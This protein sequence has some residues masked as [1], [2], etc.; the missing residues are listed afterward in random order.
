MSNTRYS[1]QGELYLGDKYLATVSYVL[2][3]TPL[4][5]GLERAVFAS[6]SGTMKVIEGERNLM[7]L[8]ATFTLHM[9]DDQELDVLI[10]SQPA[11]PL[12]Q[13]GG[14]YRITSTGTIRPS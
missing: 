2:T 11:I 1:G 9:E 13:Y 5:M 7:P 3:H 4:R 12:P 6:T 14:E 10:G 8:R